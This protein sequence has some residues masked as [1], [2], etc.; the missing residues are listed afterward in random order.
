MAEQDGAA[1]ETLR[2]WE[3]M[4]YFVVVG[5]ANRVATEVNLPFCQEK[6]RYRCCGGVRA[7][8]PYCRVRLLQLLA[9]LR[10]SES[11]PLQSIPATNDFILKRHQAALS[12]LL[13]GACRNGRGI[14]ISLLA[15]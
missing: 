3:P 4:Q 7:G 2:V 10:I 5:Y 8:A 6:R 9:V 13:R 15:G 11:G 14:R 12:E 1:G